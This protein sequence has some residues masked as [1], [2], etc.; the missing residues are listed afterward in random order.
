[1]KKTWLTVMAVA[2]LLIAALPVA[3]QS[4]NPGSGTA[5]GAVQNVDSTASA[6]FTQEFYDPSGAMDANRSKSNVAYGDT[7]GL[8]TNDTTDAPLSQALPAGWVGSS[9]VSSDREAAAVVLINYLNGAIGVDGITSVDYSGELNP[10]SDIF[11][12]TVGKRNIEDSSI[13]VMNTSDSE[14]TDVEISFRD[15]D[16]NIVGTAKTGITIPAKAQVT[17]NLFD[18]D[19]ALPDNFLGAARVQ[20]A[21]GTP[22]AVVS[23]THYT[24]GGA[25]GSFAYNCQ[26]TSAAATTL[27]AP[28]VQ[29]RVFG[30]V[31][32]DSSGVIVVNTE[33]TDAQARVEFYDREGTFS[34]VF[35]DTVPAYS[36]RGYNTQFYG[37][38]D[39]DVIDGLIGNGTADA[40]IWQGSAVVTSVSGQALVGV[41]KQ[42]Y[43]NSL[44][45]A[46]YNMLSDADA[47]QNWFFPLVYRRG[48][49][50]PWTDYIGI[51]CQNVSATDVAPTVEYV[52]RRPAAEKCTSG[53]TT[54]EFTDDT[55]FGQ[56]VSHGYNTRYGGN[57]DATWYGD[58]TTGAT[59]ENL[60]KNF[61][62]AAFVTASADI[63]C[64]QETWAEE[65]YDGTLWHD[66]GDANLNNVYGK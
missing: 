29:R 38:A 41:V 43:P 44:W 14:V 53:T 40:P 8:T 30:G 28:K 35:T 47:N 65:V 64:I 2:L 11:C 34:G 55:P 58:P 48:F 16:G 52:D 31:W 32:F 49:A 5:Y 20:S 7:M 46:A 17:F 39:H 59:G 63:V 12:P 9:V 24:A 19:F 66:G 22:L 27:Y 62:G 15:R 45:A 23:L 57:Q 60:D 4:P 25:A 37:N 10:G 61:I 3:A 56:Y 33:G 36:A 18:A 50:K 13:I 26:P 42:A 54:C 1:M 51:I 6:T 21:G